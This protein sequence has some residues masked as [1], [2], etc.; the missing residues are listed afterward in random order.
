MPGATITASWTG[1]AAPTARD[2]IGI[3]VPGAPNTPSLAWRYTTGTASGSVPFA[4]PA[5]LAPGTYELRLFS[6]DGHTRLAASNSFTVG[7]T[8]GSLSA[9][10]TSIAAGGSLTA[11]WSGVCAPTTG[12]WIG[13]YRPGGPDSPSLAWLSTTGTASGS[14]PFAIPAT[15]APGTYELRV[16]SNGGYTRLAVSNSFTVTAVVGCVGPNLSASPASVPAGGSVTAPWSGICAPTGADWVGLHILGTPDTSY[17][18]WRYTTGTPSGSVPFTIPATLAPGTY[19]LRLFSNGG[20]TQLAVSNS[21]T[22]VGCTGGNLSASPTS[23]AAGGSVTAAW[24]NI[25]APTSRDW[26]GLFL[27]GAPDTSYVAWRYTTGTASGNVP[28]TVPATLAPGTYE[29]RLFS[30]NGY[31][32]LGTSNTFAVA[33]P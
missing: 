22:V 20:Y 25:C 5:T 4:I 9:S 30:N 16:F 26:I 29:L 3:F 14:V 31:T 11:A 15:L 7:C 2:W 12:D 6:N 21:L 19:E 10:P 18:A 1:I 24:S 32:R 23:V 33:S 27:P 13:L 28:L 17:L 8:T